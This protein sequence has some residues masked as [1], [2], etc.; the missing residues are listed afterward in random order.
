MDRSSWAPCP[1][2]YIFPHVSFLAYPSTLRVTL[3]ATSYWGRSNRKTFSETSELMPCRCDRNSHGSSTPVCMEISPA[4]W[5]LPA[6]TASLVGHWLCVP[7]RLLLTQLKQL[8]ESS[9]LD[10][11]LKMSLTRCGIRREACDANCWQHCSTM[12]VTQKALVHFVLILREGE[13]G[14]LGFATFFFFF[15]RKKNIPQ[16]HMTA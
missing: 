7:R 8:T 14:W 9:A 4:L 16:R 10:L 13:G 6:L 2:Q 12:D 15:L 3:T 1:F 11:S 5:C